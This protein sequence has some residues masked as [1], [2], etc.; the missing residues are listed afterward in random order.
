[1]LMRPV[2]T[3]NRNHATRDEPLRSLALLACTGAP[4]SRVTEP[5]PGGFGPGHPPRAQ[6]RLM[7]RSSNTSRFRNRVL[8]ERAA[9]MWDDP[10]TT[11]ALLFTALRAGQLGVSFKRQAAVQM[12]S[13]SHG[14]V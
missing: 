10:T 14:C 3:T 9:H 8:S 7:P 1:L 12:P 6:E 11:E 2:P 4:N 5:A 13:R